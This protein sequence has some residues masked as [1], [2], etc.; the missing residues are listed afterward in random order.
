MSLKKPLKLPNTLAFR[1]TVWYTGIFTVSVLIALLA[2]YLLIT[3]VIQ[4]HVDETLLADVKEFASFIAAEGTDKLKAEIDREALSEGVE[5]IF[6]RVLSLDGE[7]LASTDMSYWGKVASGPQALRQLKNGADCVFETLTIS[8]HG[9]QARVIYSIIWPG[10]IL[11]MGESLDEQAEFLAIFREVIGPILTLG[12][13]FAALLG[14]FMAKRALMGVEEVTQTALRISKGDFNTRVPVKNRGDEIE[15]LATTFNDML[16]HIKTLIKEMR[17]ITDNIAHD[18]RSPLTKIRCAAELELTGGTTIDNYKTMAANTI[19]ECD[20]LLEMINTMLDIA[21]A[22]S[23]AAQLALEEVDISNLIR[24]ACDL[25][26]PV[27]ENNKISLISKVPDSYVLHSDFRKLQRIIA[28]LLD[29]AL[30]YTQTGGTVTV[31]LEANTQQITVSVT[32]TGTGISADD[33]PRIFERFYRC[34]QSRSQE[35]NG[36]GLSLVRAFAHS[37]GGDV[38]AASCPCKGSTFT[39][40][41]PSSLFLSC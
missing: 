20:R 8:E 29:N 33:L 15:R 24:D 10:I 3:S 5:K 35:G 12:T 13:I 34:G 38:K 39:V 7:E 4:G 1:L 17:E 37:L 28:N 32:D 2:F 9:H 18:M 21:E 27:A 25:F 40:I 36:L 22:E 16:D 19:E 23:G 14:W 30:K 6:V 11:Q 41:L 26:Q 31:S